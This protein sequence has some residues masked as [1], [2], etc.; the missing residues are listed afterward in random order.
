MKKIFIFIFL[1]ILFSK[2]SFAEDKESKNLDV[3]KEKQKAEY[4]LVKMK[5]NYISCYVFYTITAEGFRRNVEKKLFAEGL[6]LSAETSLKNVYE[7]GE[8]LNIEIHKITENIESEMKSQSDEM[9]NR[10]INLSL[11]I[12]KYAISCKNLIQNI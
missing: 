2:N 5:E 11:L 4:I 8:L 1:L 12:D 7:I 3:N 6:D 9:G 10:Y